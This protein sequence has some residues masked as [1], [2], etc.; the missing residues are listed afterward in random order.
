MKVIIMAENK[1]YNIKPSKI[2]EGGF[3]IQDDEKKHSF[4]TIDDKSHLIMYEKALNEQEK[5]IQE[6]KKE[7]RSFEPVVFKNRSMVGNYGRDI[8]LYQKK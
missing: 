7:L 4:P 6:L 8:I 1:R 5:I 2:I 3:C